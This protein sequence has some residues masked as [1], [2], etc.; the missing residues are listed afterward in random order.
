MAGLIDPQAEVARL[1]KRITKIRDEITRAA[2]KLAN[3]NFVRNAPPEVVT[4]ERTRIA[5]FERTLSSLE[6]QLLRVRELL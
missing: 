2:A 6:S 1:G 5:E 4:Q 3:E